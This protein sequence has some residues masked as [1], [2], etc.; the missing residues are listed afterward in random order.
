MAEKVEKA[1]EKVLNA[2]QELDPNMNVPVPPKGSNLTVEEWL[3]VLK[4]YYKFLKKVNARGGSEVNF[5]EYAKN[6]VLK[7]AANKFKEILMKKFDEKTKFVETIR[8]GVSQPEGMNKSRYNSMVEGSFNVRIYKDEN[9]ERNMAAYLSGSGIRP[10]VI[11]IANQVPDNVGF[12]LYKNITIPGSVNNIST[13]SSGIRTY[14]SGSVNDVSKVIDKLSS[15]ELPMPGV[16]RVKQNNV[17]FTGPSGSGKTTFVDKYVEKLGSYKLT[18]FAPE[19]AFDGGQIVTSKSNPMGTRKY[20]RV[21]FKTEKSVILGSVSEFKARFVRPTPFNKESSRTHLIYNANGIYVYD[22]AGKENPIDMSIRALGFNIFDKDIQPETMRSHKVLSGTFRK[23][24]PPF[25]NHLNAKTPFEEFICSYIWNIFKNPNDASDSTAYKK[26]KSEIKKDKGF[27]VDITQLKLTPY[28]KNYPEQ[29]KAI[30]DNYVNDKIKIVPND[31]KIFQEKSSAQNQAILGKP[32]VSLAQFLFDTLSR[33]IEGYYIN[34]TLHE[35]R[36]V[37]APDLF[38]SF[39]NYMKFTK[40][41]YGSSGAYIERYN[42]NKDAFFSIDLEDLTPNA[43]TNIK[44][45][46]MF[47][48]SPKQERLSKFTE[49][50]VNQGKGGGYILVGVINGSFKN[51]KNIQLSKN[52]YNNFSSYLSPKETI[53]DY[54]RKRAGSPKPQ[55]IAKHGARTALNRLTK[56]P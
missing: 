39:N 11:I 9:Y 43:G 16:D 47:Y 21:I 42:N 52:A 19:I 35:I 18:C 8:R 22:L 28:S 54:F 32:D 2:I 48:P 53:E 33:C 24:Y 50:I 13:S 27:F 4:E 3:S 10:K 56:K 20:E 30:F 44:N 23:D 37:F 6:K 29:K 15:T 38:P 51:N 26:I 14:R 7:N 41:I 34:M 25:A 46:I 1:T 5:S 36:H 17:F 45:F 12:K 31:M 40:N 55:I 49:F